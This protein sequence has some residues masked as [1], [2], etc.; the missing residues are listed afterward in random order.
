VAD[1]WRV[2]IEAETESRAWVFASYVMALDAEE[3]R[4]RRERGRP[5]RLAQPRWTAVLVN[6]DPVRGGGATATNR[7][8]ALK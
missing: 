8:E 5:C 1:R 4:D 3:A 6:C 2:F 7:S